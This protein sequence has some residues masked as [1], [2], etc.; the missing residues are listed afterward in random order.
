MSAYQLCEVIPLFALSS[1]TKMACAA[2][3]LYCCRLDQNAAQH[4]CREHE[5]Q[6]LSVTDS[7]SLFKKHLT[8]P[9]AVNNP[10]T[11]GEHE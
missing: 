2:Y 1:C 7:S 3:C 8:V 9:Y 10:M 5:M 11:P 6:G 4:S